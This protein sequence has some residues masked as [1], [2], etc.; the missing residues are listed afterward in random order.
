MNERDS[1]NKRKEK[2]HVVEIL[3]SCTAW[4]KMYVIVTAEHVWCALTPIKNRTLVNN[5]AEIDGRWSV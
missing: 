4:T 5:S 1:R 2:G 3:V